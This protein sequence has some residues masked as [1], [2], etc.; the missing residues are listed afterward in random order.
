MENELEIQQHVEAKPPRKRRRASKPKA[1]E[2]F[3]EPAWKEPETV[4]S[5]EVASVEPVKAVAKPAPAAEVK[6]W[7][8]PVRPMR[9][10]KAEGVQ[11]GVR[12]S[13]R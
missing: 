3:S 1:K 8:K 2:Q 12:K 13:K 11:R 10:R 5:E 6:P 9:Q 7:V 4:V